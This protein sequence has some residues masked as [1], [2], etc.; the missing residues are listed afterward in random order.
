MNKFETYIH[1][2][3]K[4]NE[5]PGYIGL[6]YKTTEDSFFIKKTRREI[7][8]EEITRLIHTP[9]YGKIC[10]PEY[11]TIIPN[12]LLSTTL[13]PAFDLNEIEEMLSIKIEKYVDGVE[14]EYIAARTE[15]TSEGYWKLFIDAVLYDKVGKQREEI[16]SEIG[17]SF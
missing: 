8:S 16:K 11:G 13:D 12:L 2:T 15:Q 14:V 1:N 5:E 7:I 10:D 17:G 4:S 3:N 6:N 9:I